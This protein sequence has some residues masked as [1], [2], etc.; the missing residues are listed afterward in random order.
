M[1][2]SRPTQSRS[3]P[4]SDDRVD[5]TVSLVERN[6][7]PGAVVLVPVHVVHRLMQ[8]AAEGDVELLKAA[9]DG[10]QRRLALDGGADERKRQRVA[11]TDRALSGLDRRFLAVM[12]RRDI[13][14]AA[15]QQD[16]VGDLQ[17]GADIRRAGAK[18]HE[19]RLAFGDLGDRRR[20]FAA[21]GVENV[22]F[23]HLGAGRDDDDRTAHAAT[24]PATSPSVRSSTR[25]ITASASSNWSCVQIS[26]GA[27]TMVSN[28]ARMMKPSRKK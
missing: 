4:R 19:Q 10:K 26:G 9:A 5:R 28:T 17:H 21:H 1:I 2:S 13:R 27:M 16:G 3:L 15:R 18:R 6:I 20:V 23:D 7:G 12:L 24:S 14:E 11:Q 22:V 25:R 8:A